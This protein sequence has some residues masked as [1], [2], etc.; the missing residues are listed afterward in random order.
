MTALPEGFRVL[1]GTDLLRVKDARHK[2]IQGLSPLVGDGR[3]AGINDFSRI[4][5]PIGS[6]DTDRDHL[7][8]L[9]DA[10][11]LVGDSSGWIVSDSAIAPNVVALEVDLAALFEFATQTDFYSGDGLV[12]E[13]MKSW[14]KDAVAAAYPDSSSNWALLSPRLSWG[15]LNTEN[16]DYGFTA[17]AGTDAF[18]R[19]YRQRRPVAPLD[20]VIWMHQGAYGL[21]KEPPAKWN[22]FRRRL[23]EGPPTRRNLLVRYMESFYGREDSEWLWGL[24]VETFMDGYSQGT[25]QGWK[26]FEQELIARI[27]SD[28]AN[29][30]RLQTIWDESRAD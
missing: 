19:E 25:L 27:K 15:Y 12:P 8:A 30:L 18:M 10:A 6:I 3:T 13:A 20:V 22:W 4:V 1:I 28:P 2:Y 23:P 14:P 26:K 16:D 11:A 29:E 7:S 21:I 24:Y 17:I 9:R 5:R